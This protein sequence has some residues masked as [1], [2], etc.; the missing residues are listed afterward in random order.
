M[1][2]LE[3]EKMTYEE[4]EKALEEILNN[5]DRSEIPVDQLVEQA[6][7]AKKLMAAMKATLDAAGKGLEEVFQ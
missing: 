6:A 3:I 7:T 2:I 4:K 1:G 5:L